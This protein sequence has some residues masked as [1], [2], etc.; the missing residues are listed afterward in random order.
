MSTLFPVAGRMSTGYHR[1][2]VEEFFERAR[3]AY[4]SGDAVSGDKPPLTEHDVRTVAFDLVRAGYQTAAVDAALDRLE[5]ALVQRDRQRYISGRGQQ[6]WMDSIAELAT[7]L[8]PRLV[9][10]AGKRFAPPESGKGYD[11]EAV[12]EVMDR[13]VAYFDADAE[14]SAGSLRTVVFPVARGPKAYAEG[15]VDAFLDRAV[16]VLLAVE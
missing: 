1:E 14:L 6:A 15:P 12:D 3:L 11:R 7:T 2:Q 13:L 8:Y 5:A 4:E 10:P 16:E 9:R